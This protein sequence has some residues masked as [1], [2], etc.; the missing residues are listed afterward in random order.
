MK[1][2]ALIALSLLILP[3][4]SRQETLQMPP[5]DQETA[6]K[7]I[8]EAVR[9]IFQ[10][11]EKMD[12]EALFQSYSNSMD[13]IFFTT[14]GSILNLQE[15]KSHHAA[16]F[17]SLSSLKVTSLRDDFRFSDGGTVICSWTGKFEMTMM[18]GDKYVINQFGITFIF[19]K[20]SNSWKVIYQHSSALPPV[21]RNI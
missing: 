3:G 21:R 10:N 6:K 13:L 1:T 12:A 2:V 15:A 19:R 14:D 4:Y 16:W 11:L 20:I 8:R 18:S 5:Q 7:E 17:N 9:V